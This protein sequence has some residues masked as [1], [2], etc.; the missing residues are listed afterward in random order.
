MIYD[1]DDT[2]REAARLALAS[3]QNALSDAENVILFD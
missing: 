3:A 1:E 2:G